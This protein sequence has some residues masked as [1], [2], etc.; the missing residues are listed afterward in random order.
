MFFHFRISLV[1]NIGIIEFKNFFFRFFFLFGTD[2]FFIMRNVIKLILLL[3]PLAFKLI[4]VIIDL[5]L[6]LFCFFGFSIA[7]LLHFSLYIEE[8]RTIFFKQFFHSGIMI[9]RVFIHLNNFLKSCS[10]VFFIKKV[11]SF[12]KCFN[13]TFNRVYFFIHSFSLNP[14]QLLLEIFYL[15]PDFKN[16]F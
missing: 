16:C 15:S 2:R 4:K 6:M 9:G 5:F 12:L 8:S 10:F 11:P 14:L 3:P 13:I 7:F 1:K